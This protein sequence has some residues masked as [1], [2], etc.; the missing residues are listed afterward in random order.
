MEHMHVSPHFYRFLWYFS[1]V[2]ANSFL[3]I[4]LSSKAAR[5]FESLPLR[6]KSLNDAMR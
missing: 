5:G 3:E 2:R 4:V 1:I 6:Q